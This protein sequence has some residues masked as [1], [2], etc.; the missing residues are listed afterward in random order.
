MCLGD[1]DE[2]FWICFR[3]AFAQVLNTDTGVDQDRDGTDFEQGK[4]Q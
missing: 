1:T 4:R 2:C 3:K